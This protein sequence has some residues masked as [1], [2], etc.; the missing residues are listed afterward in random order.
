MLFVH[1][2]EVV[3]ISECLL[4]E[5]SLYSIS[6]ASMASHFKWWHTPTN[7]VVVMRR[8]DGEVEQARR[9]VHAVS[10]HS[11]V[12]VSAN[13][14]KWVVGEMVIVNEVWNYMKAKNKTK[15]TSASTVGVIK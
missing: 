8:R 2:I 10:C 6:F 14:P 1:C 12:T 9:D 3:R 11:S 7:L 15:K 4:L 13:E 5:V